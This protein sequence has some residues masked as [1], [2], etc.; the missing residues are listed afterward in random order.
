MY[1]YKAVVFDFDGTLFDTESH[2]RKTLAALVEQVT[3]CYPS[4]EKLF[5]RLGMTQ[6]RRPCNIWAVMRNRW[7]G[8]GRVGMMLL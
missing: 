2:E 8:C 7:N 3:G 4:E 1:C 5:D 6:V